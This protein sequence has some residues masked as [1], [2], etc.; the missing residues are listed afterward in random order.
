M[1]SRDKEL[2]IIV[3]KLEKLKNIL[4]FNRY[5]DLIIFNLFNSIITIIYFLFNGKFYFDLDR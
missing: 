4:I 3:K 5:S 1:K 2:F